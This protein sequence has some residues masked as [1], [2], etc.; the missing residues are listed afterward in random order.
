MFYLLFSEHSLGSFVSSMDIHRC[1]TLVLPYWYHYPLP[2][3]CSLVRNVSSSPF[4]CGWILLCVLAA[5]F[6][7]RGTDS[8]TFA[9]FQRYHSHRQ[10]SWEVHYEDACCSILN[11]WASPLHKYLIYRCLLRYPPICSSHC[12][13]RDLETLIW[14]FCLRC[15]VLVSSD[16]VSCFIVVSVMKRYS[17]GWLAQL[18]LVVSSELWK[19]MKSSPK[20]RGR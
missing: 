5:S 4:V 1:T 8:S 7:A 11:W 9:V 18:V 2:R 3:Q 19:F 12:P 13:L 15:G 10:E 20:I 16:V 17:G 6:L 14:A